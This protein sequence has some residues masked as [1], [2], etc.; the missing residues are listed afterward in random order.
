MDQVC[1]KTKCKFLMNLEESKEITEN[2]VLY[3]RINCPHEEVQILF[4]QVTRD[5]MSTLQCFRIGG[6]DIPHRDSG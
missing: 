3:S 4:L 1:H 2:L 5:G 6:E